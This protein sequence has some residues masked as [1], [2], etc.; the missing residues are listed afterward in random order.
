MNNVKFLF[1]SAS[2]LTVYLWAMSMAIAYE[3]CLRKFEKMLIYVTWPVF[4]F[5]YI[6]T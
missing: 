3:K 1:I 4:S 6:E 2:E 5:S